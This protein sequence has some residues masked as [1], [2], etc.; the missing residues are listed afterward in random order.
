MNKKA[1]RIAAAH[2]PMRMV[3]EAMKSKLP[4]GCN[5]VLIFYDDSNIVDPSVSWV[6][7][8]SKEMAVARMKEFVN[9]LGD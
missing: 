8:E 7:S 2:E 5:F 1:D 3:A 9:Q 6:A 4:P